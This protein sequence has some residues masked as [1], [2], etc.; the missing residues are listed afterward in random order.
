MAKVSGLVGERVISSKVSLTIAVILSFLIAPSKVAAIAYALLLGG[1][2]VCVFV[3][4]G[5]VSGLGTMILKY[6]RS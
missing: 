2:V 6:W 3:G 5:M 4:I 1:I